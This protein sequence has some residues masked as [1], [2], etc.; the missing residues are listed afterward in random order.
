MGE[1]RVE[2][3]SMGEV[4]VPASAYYGA[5]TQRAADNFPISGWRFGRRFIQALGLV[6]WAA[7]QANEDLDLLPADIA[8]AIR[9]A[10]EE[11]I[12]GDHDDQFVI[13]VFQ[14]GSGTSTNMNANEVIANRASELLGGVRGSKYP[15]HPND[16]VNRC[17]S[18]NDVIPTVTH[19]AALT[20]IHEALLPSL[21]HLSGTLEDKASV[22]DGIL[23]SGRTHLMDA[24]PVRLGQEFAG[25]ASQVSHAIARLQRTSIHL[26]E[27]AL[28]GTAVGTGINAHPEF[29]TRAIAHLRRRSGFELVE[30]PDHFEAQ[31]ARDAVV[32]ASGALKTVAVSLARIAND[33]RWLA[34]G[35][36]TGIAEIRLPA[37]QPGSS[38]M[39]GKVNP[40]IPEAVIQVAAQVIG[41]DAAITLGGLGSIFELNTMMPLMAHDL[42][43]SIETLGAAAGLLAERC[44]EGIEADAARARELLERSL[45]I[46]T[47][48]VPLIGYD[49]AAEVSKEAYA[50]GRSLREIVVARG[51]LTPEEVDTALDL[52]RMT[53]PGLGPAGSE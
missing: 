20:A 50:T 43:F 2:K 6:K 14:T 1:T 10:A 36:R 3:D 45:V 37:L 12:A 35:P 8:R 31:G 26:G 46:V 4:E 24:T 19:L 38:I 44:V 40:V 22:F 27:I 47:A 42:L 18:S 29:A 15:V 34:S 17:Q 11:V 32:E 25:Y 30:A 48:L 51:L 28:G 53:E 39:P 33:L 16:H 9:D 21:V 23:K 5:Q 7:A 49:A 41:N 13:D 52:R